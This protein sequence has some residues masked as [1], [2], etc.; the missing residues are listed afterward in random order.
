M[1]SSPNTTISSPPTPGKVRRP[2][3]RFHF[4]IESLWA[5]RA[6]VGIDSTTLD[7]TNK[8]CSHTV[9]RTRAEGKVGVWMDLVTVGGGRKRSG[10]SIIRY[11]YLYFSLS[12]LLS[13]LPL[14]V[15][16]VTI[17][18]RPSF[19]NNIDNNNPS[20]TRFNMLIMIIIPHLP[21]FTIILMP[22]PSM[23]A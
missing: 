1:P 15:F 19:F 2:V 21:T 3:R 18:K 9:S 4:R 23:A 11:H 16:K 7:Q 6:L 13:Y 14:L 17:I 20:I 12:L 8:I 22:A 10:R 5:F